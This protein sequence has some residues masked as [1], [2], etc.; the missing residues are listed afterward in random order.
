MTTSTL[1]FGDTFTLPATGEHEWIIRDIRPPYAHLERRDAWTAVARNR[2]LILNAFYAPDK[3]WHVPQHETNHTAIQAQLDEL[4]VSL[5]DKS[6]AEWSQEYRRLLRGEVL[7]ET[8]EITQLID[9]WTKGTTI[10]TLE[11][12]AH[13]AAS[14]AVAAAGTDDVALFDTVYRATHAYLTEHQK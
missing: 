7:R 3:G 6:D 13:V 9:T 1:S 14:A 11:L 2:E 12:R 5:P 8:A 10:D 4:D